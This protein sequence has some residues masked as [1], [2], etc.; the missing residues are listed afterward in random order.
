MVEKRSIKTLEEENQALRK[1][2]KALQETQALWEFARKS[3]DM[4]SWTYD[5]HNDEMTIDRNEKKLRASQER[6]QDITKSKQAEDEKAKLENLLRQ[7]QK[8][9]AIGS[10]A[11]GI[12]HDFNNILLPIIG[13]AELLMEDLSKESGQHDMLK[14]I[15]ASAVRAS[16]LVKQILTFSR[17]TEQE[18]HPLKI[19][20]PIKESLELLRASLPSTIKIK[21]NLDQN[22]GEVLAAPTHIHQVSMNLITNAFHAMEETG[23]VLEVSLSQVKLSIK[24]LINPAMIPGDYACLTVSDTGIGMDEKIVTEIFEPYFTTKGSNRGT[25]LGLSV[26]RGI[27]KS[28]NGD[29]QAISKPGKGTRFNVFL[30][31]VADRKEAVKIVSQKTA[32]KG[33]ERILL[34]DDEL[35]IVEMYTQML[36]RLGYKVTPHTSSVSALETIKSFPKSID[37]V[38]TDMTMPDM[39]GV[40]LSQKI[41]A[42]RPDMPIILC[43]GFS[44]K[45]SQEKAKALGICGFVLKPVTKQDIAQKI[46][47]V[48]DVKP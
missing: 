26:V 47:E 8:M 29:I 13:Y 10:L 9:E 30:P 45:I 5:R 21:Q 33:T 41:M 34:V 17:Q 39:T 23:G 28:Y 12:A 4:G 35:Y 37:L 14:R 43:T 40:Q 16:D 32:P 25:G 46:R 22:C 48:L 15:L 36:E 31:L 18:L 6:T 42:I 19:Q 27:V 2:V 20:E 38:I 24:D 1:K 11:S 7:S 44:G 3:A